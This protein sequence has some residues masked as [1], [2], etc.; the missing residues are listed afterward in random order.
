MWGACCAWTNLNGGRCISSSEAY[1]R[2]LHTDTETH[3]TQEPIQQK[4][5]QMWP[6]NTFCLWGIRL[7]PTANV[8]WGEI[9]YF[10]CTVSCAAWHRQPT[11]TI[12]S[13]GRWKT[14]PPTTGPRSGRVTQTS[15]SEPISKIDYGAK[16]EVPLSP[17]DYELYRVNNLAVAR[18]HLCFLRMKPT[19]E[20]RN[21]KGEKRGDTDDIVLSSKF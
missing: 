2:S 5:Q 17:W 18:D 6:S 1:K 19:L 15:C 21:T 12:D 3:R 8:L 13:G 11:L 14:L 9:F 4:Q 20:K 7:Q 16:W 10:L